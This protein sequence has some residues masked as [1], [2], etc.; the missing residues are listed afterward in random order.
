MKLPP[1]VIL[2][3]S[4]VEA[5]IA[6]LAAPGTALLAGGQGIL[7]R[8]RTGETRAGRLVA[9]SDVHGLDGVT[10][11]DGFLEIGARVTLRH[12]A[13][14]SA[15][16]GAP[17]L[18]DA[19]RHVGNEAVR[20]LATI[21]GNLGHG[22]ATCE[23]LLALAAAGGRAHF[24][25]AD[26]ERQEVAGDALLGLGAQVEEGGL[27]TGV[28]FPCT[29]LGASFAEFGPQ[30]MWVPE[31]AVAAAWRAGGS[32]AVALAVGEGGRRLFTDVDL[33]DAR[34]DIA[35]RLATDPLDTSLPAAWIAAI[36]AHHASLAKASRREG[37]S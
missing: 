11:R 24:T 3:P 5:V 25:R 20:T 15:Q 21:G 27:V 32:L 36:A 2:R 1:F 33:H 22:V 30:G 28:G 7:F 18:A 17:L 10:Q 31:L 12:L 37:A 4:S 29:L 8:L 13:A 16:M 9:L 19:A 35:S 14:V 6:E 34:S 23:T 26:G